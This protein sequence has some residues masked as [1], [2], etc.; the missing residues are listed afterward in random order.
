LLLAN[1]YF[2]LESVDEALATLEKI[3][4]SSAELRQRVDVLKL[5]AEIY[6]QKGKYGYAIDQYIN[7]EVMPELS[8]AERSAAAIRIQELQDEAMKLQL[9]KQQDQEN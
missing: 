4:L 9:K 3:D 2:Q 7:L 6:Q 8:I 1:Y 5:K